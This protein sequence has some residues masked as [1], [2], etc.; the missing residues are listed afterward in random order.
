M[1]H[2]AAHSSPTNFNK[3]SKAPTGEP[4]IILNISGELKLGSSKWAH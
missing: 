4:K 1:Q 2:R 3:F